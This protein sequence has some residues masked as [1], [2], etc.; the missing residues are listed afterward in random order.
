MCVVYCNKVTH[1]NSDLRYVLSLSCLV[2]SCLVLSCLVLSCQIETVGF[3]GIRGRLPTA[4]VASHILAGSFS[5]Y[6]R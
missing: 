4:S 6:L 3:P 1:Y 2:L 5:V